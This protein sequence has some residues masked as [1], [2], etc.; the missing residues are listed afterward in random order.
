MLPPS[1]SGIIIQGNANPP[2]SLKVLLPEENCLG[3][4]Q[5]A[6]D[7]LLW[8]FYFCRSV[9]CGVSGV[10]VSSSG[11]LVAPQFCDGHLAVM[12]SRQNELT[13]HQN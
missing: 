10:Q 1:T 3:V 4:G 12:G 9:G 2:V 11:S 13:Q 5:R 7:A 8:T 6:E